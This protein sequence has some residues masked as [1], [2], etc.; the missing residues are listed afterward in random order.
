KIPS[1]TVARII[2]NFAGREGG[3]GIG[4][5][6]KIL[7]RESRRTDG[8]VIAAVAAPSNAAKPPVTP[9]L[10]HPG[11][12]SLPAGCLLLYSQSNRRTAAPTPSPPSFSKMEWA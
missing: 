10:D 12:D 1:A 4:Q 3:S 2:R 11:R 8:I 7:E 9:W 5:I 6:R